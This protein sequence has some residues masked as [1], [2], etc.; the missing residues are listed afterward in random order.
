[1]DEAAQGAVD[2]VLTRAVEE[3]LAEDAQADDN[4]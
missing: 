4:Q 1:V 2:D 3:A